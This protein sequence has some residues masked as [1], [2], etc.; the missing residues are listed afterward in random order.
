MEELEQPMEQT[1][2]NVNFGKFKD[3]ESLLK[4][5]TSLE[6]EFTKKSQKLATLEG[7]KEIQQNSEKKQAELDEKLENF[8]SKFEFVKPSTRNYKD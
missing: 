5:Y 3:A 8:I 2:S 1:G 6:A 4:A 7:E